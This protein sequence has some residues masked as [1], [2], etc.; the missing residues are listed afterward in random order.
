VD[1]DKQLA[2]KTKEH[3]EGLEVVEKEKKEMTDR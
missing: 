3:E 2:D 1:L